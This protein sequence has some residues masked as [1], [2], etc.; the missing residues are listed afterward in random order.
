M[1]AENERS[2]VRQGSFATCSD[3]Q[4]NIGTAVGAVQSLPA[5][6]YIAINGR[7]WDPLWVRKNIEMNR[8]EAVGEEGG[9]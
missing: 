9:R 1:H 4:F 6:V 7:I 8:F 3:A 5:G 2:Q